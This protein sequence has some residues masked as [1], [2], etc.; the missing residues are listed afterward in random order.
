MKVAQTLIQMKDVSDMILLDTLLSQEDRTR[1]YS[2]QSLL[3]TTIDENGKVDRKNRILKLKMESL[4]PQKKSRQRM[5]QK[6]TLVREM[7][8]K[9]NDCGVDVSKRSNMMSRFPPSNKLRHMSRKL[10][11]AF[12][13]FANR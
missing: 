13:E 5:A 2:L 10:I 8:L 4:S 9:D 6:G 7:I 12:M 1:Q 11:L 3:G